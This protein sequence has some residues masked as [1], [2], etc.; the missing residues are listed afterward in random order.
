MCEL[1]QR[2]TCL[3]RSGAKSDLQ[4]TTNVG[5]G[6][7]SISLNKDREPDEDV[8]G[9]I[10]EGNDDSPRSNAIHCERFDSLF[11]LL[12]SCTNIAPVAPEA[13]LCSFLLFA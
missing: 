1:Y 3:A 9:E 8:N 12:K 4:P 2:Q 6:V 11:L 10:V 7:L 13:I 5:I